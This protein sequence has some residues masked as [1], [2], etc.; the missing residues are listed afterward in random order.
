MSFTNGDVYEGLWNEDKM[1]GSGTYVFS[2]GDKY[3]GMFSENMFN[4]TGTYTFKKNKK[5]YTGT[6]VN[7]SYKG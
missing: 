2:N 3:E 1:S 6:W 5:E 7:N 4:G